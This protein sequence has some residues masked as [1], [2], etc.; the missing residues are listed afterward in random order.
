MKL[1]GGWCCDQSVI[2]LSFVWGAYDRMKLDNPAVDDRDL[3]RSLTQL[4]EVRIRREMSGD[5]PFYI[6]H[7]PYERETMK[8]PPAQP[9]QYDLA[10]VLNAD[11]RIM[12]P[13]EAKV[14]ETAKAV[15]E[16]VLEVR[17]QFLACRYAPFC[18]EGAMLG[19]LLT[20]SPGEA[21]TNIAAKVPCTLEEHPKFPSRA[22]RTSRHR[23]TVPAGKRYPADFCCHHLI[24]E[25]F[26]LKRRRP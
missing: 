25:F 11:E 8:R 20:G 22:H 23:R 3:E 13:L 24:L 1:A 26:G 19:Y 15:S 17:E 10:F 12:W 2:L 6:Q 18:S 9:P 14:L 7:G 16:Y 21:F 5:E 4:F